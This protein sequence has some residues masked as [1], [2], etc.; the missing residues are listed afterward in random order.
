MH[1]TFVTKTYEQFTDA[2]L[3][4]LRADPPTDESF[5]VAVRIGKIMGEHAHPGE[6]VLQSIAHEAEVQQWSVEVSS[7]IGNLAYTGTQR[8]YF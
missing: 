4:L 2:E 8:G 6:R 1:M 3:S 5:E 7:I